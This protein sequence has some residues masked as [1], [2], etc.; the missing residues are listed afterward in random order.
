MTSLSWKSLTKKEKTLV[1]RCLA[2]RKN[3]YAPYSRFKVGALALASSGEV[4]EGCNVESA[5]YTLTTHAEMNAIN[6]MVAAGQTRLAGIVVALSSVS[7]PAV[8]CGLCRQKM[9]EFADKPSMPILCAGLDKKGGIRDL[10]RFTLAE[11]L[12]RAFS[13]RNL[14]GSRS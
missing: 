10:S 5:D 4:Y 8:P 11:L 2:V 1:R 6:A 13:K 9:T 3:A 7:G 12:P 14:A